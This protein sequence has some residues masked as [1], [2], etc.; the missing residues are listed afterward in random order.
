ESMQTWEMYNIEERQSNGAPN[1]RRYVEII[2]PTEIPGETIPNLFAFNDE[3][4]LPN[5][6]FNRIYV[7]FNIDEISLNVHF[8][9]IHE[10]RQYTAT[11]EQ[12]EP[13][14]VEGDYVVNHKDL[15]HHIEFNY[16]G[17]SSLAPHEQLKLTSI[18]LVLSKSAAVKLANA[19]FGH[20]AGV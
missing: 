18:R 3:I 10:S 8:V 13:Y 5:I 20:A 1:D 4:D 9:S 7:T 12:Q 17:H 16:D 14:L 19:L 11:R 2:F 6:L 15:T